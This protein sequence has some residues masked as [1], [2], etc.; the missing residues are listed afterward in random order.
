MAEI[1]AVRQALAAERKSTNELIDE[2]N[3]YMAASDEERRLLREQNAILKDISDAYKRQAQA[4]RERGF[5][6]LLLGLVVGVA[7]GAAAN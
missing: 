2:L 4:E 7:A 1:E 5:G 3:A 6:R